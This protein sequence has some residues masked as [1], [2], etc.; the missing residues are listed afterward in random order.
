MDYNKNVKYFN[1]SDVHF[2]IGLAILSVGVI[3][4]AAAQGF[5]WWIMPYQDVTGIIVGAVGAAI[6]WIPRGMR[7]SEKE[8]DAHIAEE[9]KGY[10]QQVIKIYSLSGKLLPMI[11][12]TVIGGYE[13]TARE[14]LMRRGKDDR[15]LRTS[16]YTAAALVFTQN[17]IVLSVKTF[18]LINSDKTEKKREFPYAALDHAA[19]IRES[20]PIQ[21]GTANIETSYFVLYENGQEC[22]RTPASQSAVLD[23]LCEDLN[24]KILMEKAAD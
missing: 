22:F 20:V 5:Q 24:H 13:Y 3:L 21:D 4:L 1:S 10:E 7:T 2:Y 18:S 12:P 8:L 17:G 6:A 15:K 16:T 19:V 9:S 14:L 23:K 11:K